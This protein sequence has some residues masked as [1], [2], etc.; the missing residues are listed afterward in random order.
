M[1]K[2]HLNPCYTAVDIVERGK[3]KSANIAMESNMVDRCHF[4]QLHHID[5]LANGTLKTIVERKKLNG[6]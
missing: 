3:A 5:Y 6:K 4:P 1:H 2:S